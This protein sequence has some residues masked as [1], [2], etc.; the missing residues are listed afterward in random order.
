MLK[1]EESIRITYSRLDTSRF[2]QCQLD[3]EK[4]KFHK[5]CHAP[6]F[7]DAAAF[8][9]LLPKETQEYTGT[10]LPSPV[11]SLGTSICFAP[12]VSFT[13]PDLFFT[14]GP[15]DEALVL[16]GTALLV[17]LSEFLDVAATFLLS[18]ASWTT[19][20]GWRD[21][22][23]TELSWQTEELGERTTYGWGK[24]ARRTEDGVPCFLVVGKNGALGGS[25]LV[26]GSE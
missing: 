1:L 14:E 18:E 20:G 24:L 17:P 25:V 16:P 8:P 2:T 15:L 11:L 6:L 23:L 13:G 21:V 19:Q 7:W 10:E 5:R 22:G 3:A 4:Q 12:G 26:K 9:L